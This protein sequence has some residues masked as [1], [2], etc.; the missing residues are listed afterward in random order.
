LVVPAG[1]RA[2]TVTR[3]TTFDPPDASGPP[4]SRA[5]I[6]V[7]GGSGFYSWLDGAHEV[8]VETP[9]GATSDPVTIGEVG[10]RTIAF[11]PR[12]GRDHRFPP[13]RV[14]YRANLWALRA[15]GVR[16]VLG[17]CAVGSMRP[18]LGPGSLVV[19]DQLIDRTW[20][21]QH[22]VYDGVGSV[23]HVAF[24]DPYCP[25]GRA[26]VVAAADDRSWPAVDG[27][28]LV[29]IN[30]PRFS[31]R[32]ESRW[33]AALGADVVGMTGM[34]EASIARE[35][36]LCYTSIAVVTDLDAGFETGEGVTHAEVFEQFGRSIAALQ[37]LLLEVVVRLPADEDC[38]CRRSLD[39]LTLPFELP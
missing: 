19:P 17:P 2:A 4:T 34:P 20:G 25:R 39:G 12:H 23:A 29:V 33:H 3:V 1:S 26:T 9:F 27:G 36:A 24:A 35:L 7:I 6:G 37:E 32:A 14:N 10:G 31:T 11:V 5:E 22:T 18:E 8:Q 15:V 28:T 16:Q 38:S 21:R 30:G 13:H